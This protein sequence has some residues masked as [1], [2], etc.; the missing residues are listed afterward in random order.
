MHLGHAGAR[1]PAGT[2]ADGHRNVAQ[3]LSKQSPRQGQ[4]GGTKP[5]FHTVKQKQVMWQQEVLTLS[6]ST[7][8]LFY[9]NIWRE[10][11]MFGG[12]TVRSRGRECLFRPMLRHPFPLRDQPHDAIV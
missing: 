10:Q 9:K 2:R 6:Q 7:N 4:R 3:C 1:A 8:A 5:A 11:N 12:G